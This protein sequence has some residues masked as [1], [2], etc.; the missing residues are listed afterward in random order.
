VPFV[1]VITISSTSAVDLISPTPRTTAHSPACST[2][3]RD[4]RLWRRMLVREGLHHLRRRLRRIDLL[5]GLDESGVVLR[6]LGF[7]F[8]E[9][10]RER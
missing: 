9:E 8:C 4:Q 6:E 3:R 7:P 2:T 10:L 1:D 5:C